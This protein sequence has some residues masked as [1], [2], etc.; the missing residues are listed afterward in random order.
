MFFN[1][2]WKQGQQAIL[3]GVNE[4]V[5]SV[6]TH[7]VKPL[8]Y[9]LAFLCSSIRC[10]GTDLHVTSEFSDVMKQTIMAM[11]EANIIYNKLAESIAPTIYGHVNFSHH[12]SC[13]A[14]SSEEF[15]SNW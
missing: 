6:T 3:H 10:E 13:R 7:G 2:R 1:G 14:I 4:G 11:R 12:L 8:T 5:T 9:R 15:F